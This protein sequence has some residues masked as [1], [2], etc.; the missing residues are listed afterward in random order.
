MAKGLRDRAAE[1]DLVSRAIVL[2]LVRACGIAA[3]SPRS[4]FDADEQRVDVPQLRKIL[5]EILAGVRDD[6]QAK[7]AGG[8]TARVYNFGVARLIGR[9]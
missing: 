6:E 1:E 7:I 5:A 8:D 4:L 2:W 3:P 9:A